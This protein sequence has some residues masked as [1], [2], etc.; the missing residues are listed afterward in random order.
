MNTTTDLRTPTDYLEWRVMLPL[1]LT[2]F[3]ILVHGAALSPL[4]A[5]VAD[6]LGTTVPLVGQVVTM[7]LA[8]MGVVAVI[9][10]PIADHIGHRRTI[11]LGLATLLVSAVVMGLAPTIWIMLFGGLIAGVGAS[12]IGIPFA[13]AATRWSGDGQQRALSRVQSAQTLGSIVGAPILTAIASATLWRGA[14]AVIIVTYAIAILLVRR[15]IAPDQRRGAGRFSM[16]M[17]LDAYRPLVSDP[18]MRHLYMASAARGMG[19]FGPLIY[20]GAFY[21]DVHGLS[22]RQVGL[23]LMAG[24]CGVFLG[25]IAAG[26]WLRGFDSRRIYSM[27][28]AA[29]AVAF[30]M[31][32]TLP[33]SAIATVIM[34]T[35]ATFCAGIGW[36]NLTTLLAS[37]S[38]AGKG[39]TMTLNVSVYTL[40]SSVSVAIGGLLIDLGGYMLLGV[41]FPAVVLLSAIV[42]WAPSHVPVAALGGRQPG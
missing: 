2:V 24:S 8:G 17:V 3:A 14:Y 18:G 20:L 35:A 6:D 23:A 12:I 40:A 37:S 26:E 38:P 11:V 10:G 34:M 25:S 36:V 22:L 41:V 30:L 4:A 5:D 29:L 9:V 21:V 32:F 16:Q 31:V 28:T 42:I 27:T 1:C 15:Y 7:I 33:L 13:V 39:T 19:W